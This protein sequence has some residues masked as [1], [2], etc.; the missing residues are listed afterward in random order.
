MPFFLKILFIFMQ[1][2]THISSEY[3]STRDITLIL[4]CER[5]GKRLILIFDDL[6]VKFVGINFS[7]FKRCWCFFFKVSHPVLSGGIALMI[8]ILVSL[9]LRLVMRKLSLSCLKKDFPF[10]RLAI[11]FMM[12]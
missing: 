6:R 10:S 11:F 2:N 1:S 5:R 9:E 12:G 7:G 4:R 8:W 3:W